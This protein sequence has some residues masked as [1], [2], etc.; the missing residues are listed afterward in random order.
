[1][2]GGARA[3]RASR[4]RRST[5]S[6]TGSPRPRP[7][8]DAPPVAD[9]GERRLRGH[10][11]GAGDGDAAALAAALRNDLEA[12][13]LCAATRAGT[14]RGAGRASTPAAPAA[15]RLRPDLRGR[16]RRPGHAHGRR[17]PLCSRPGLDGRARGH[18]SGR[19]R[20]R[21]GVRLMTN[22]L[23][24]EKVSKSYGVRILLDEVSLGVGEGERI[25]IVGR[26][27]DGKTTLLNLMAGRETPDTGRVSRQPR[28]AH[29]LPRPARPARRHPHRARGRARPAGPT[30]SGPPTRAPARWS[31]CC[32]PASPWTARCTGSPAVSAAAARWPGCCSAD[33]D[34]LILDEPTNHLDVEAVAWLADHLGAAAYVGAGGGHPRPLVPRRGLRAHLGGAPRANGAGVVDSYEGGYAAF[35]LARAERDAPGLGRGAAPAEPRC[36]RSWPGCAA[37]PRPAPRSR[38]SASTPPTS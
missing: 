33:D 36:A 37:A 12:P 35:V 16:R 19:R 26:N 23:N 7:T 20:P 11:R 13:A 1:M 31:R 32:S 38:S 18:R 25:G 34:L 5:A 22:L 3:R 24:L 6:S 8:A 10:G 2:G 4:P 9:H 17:A 29:R 15:V 28:P 21:G 30:T 14:A 27:G